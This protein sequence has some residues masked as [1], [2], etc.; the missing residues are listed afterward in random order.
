MQSLS[1]ASGHVKTL[2]RWLPC[3]RAFQV[4]L[5]VKN[6]PVNAGDKRDAGLIPGLGRSLGGGCGNPPQYSYLENPMDR[7]TWRAAVYGFS[8]LDMTEQLAMPSSRG[9]SQPRGW[10]KVSHIKGRFFTIWAASEARAHTHTHT[11]THSSFTMP[12]LIAC[13]LLISLCSAVFLTCFLFWKA[14]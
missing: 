14:V 8:E 1:L 5:V 6:L 11:Y 2:K 3:I 10:T 9:S 13:L 4:A 7:G 12:I